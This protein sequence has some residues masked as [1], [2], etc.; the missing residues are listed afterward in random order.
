MTT[1]ICG[2]VL[3]DEQLQTYLRVIYALGML[4]L[5]TSYSGSNVT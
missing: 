2:P 4:K 5:M 1:A 3:S